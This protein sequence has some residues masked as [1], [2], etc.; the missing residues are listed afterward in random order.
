[1]GKPSAGQRRARAGRFELWPVDDAQGW[2][3][4]RRG[5]SFQEGLYM[6][7]RGKWALR[8][9]ENGEPWYFQLTRGINPTRKSKRPWLP[10]GR[11]LPVNDSSPAAI[12]AHES[13]LNTQQSATA[14]MSEKE[15]LARHAKYDPD[16]PLPPEDAV[17]LAQAKVREWGHGRRAA[18]PLSDAPFDVPVVWNAFVK[19][20]K[21]AEDD[22]IE[23]RA[24]IDDDE[25]SDGFAL[26]EQLI[27]ASEC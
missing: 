6:V 27:K 14:M 10:V 19:Y 12:T 13:E 11:K 7:W 18:A 9:H 20:P 4:I 5:V 16:Q 1:M 23:E 3:P 24:A 2:A 17:E 22:A 15:K 26:I 25:Q 8:E 21:P